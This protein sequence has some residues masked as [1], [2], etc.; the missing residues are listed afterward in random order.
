MNEGVKWDAGK[1]RYDLVPTEPLEAIAEVMT[2]GANKY[3]ANNWQ[4]VEDDRYYAALMRHLIAWRKGQIYDK[5]SG[6]QHL[7][8][9]LCNVAFLLYKEGNG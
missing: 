3:G 4:N 2:Y 9:A 7:K 8:H 6:L 1:L 5:E